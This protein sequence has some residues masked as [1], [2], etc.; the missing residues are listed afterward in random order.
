MHTPTPPFQ[1]HQTSIG[2]MGF[3]LLLFSIFSVADHDRLSSSLDCI[4]RSSSWQTQE[5]ENGV[6][7]LIQTVTLHTQPPPLP[8]PPLLPL[9]PH[10]PLDPP[11]VVIH[12]Q[13]RHLLRPSVSVRS[14]TFMMKAFIKHRLYKII[15]VVAAARVTEVVYFSETFGLA[16]CGF[17]LSLSWAWALQ[18]KRNPKPGLCWLTHNSLYTDII[19]SMITFKFIDNLC[20]RYIMP[21]FFFSQLSSICVRFATNER[22]ERGNIKYKTI[23]STVDFVVC[24]NQLTMSG[25]MIVEPDSW[26]IKQAGF[27]ISHLLK[28]YKFHL[29]SNSNNDSNYDSN[30]QNDNDSDNN[31][32]DICDEASQYLCADESDVHPDFQL[33]N[34]W[35]IRIFMPFDFLDNPKFL[36]VL[37]GLKHTS[38]PVDTSRCHLE[39]LLQ[40][41]QPP[42]PTQSPPQPPPQPTQPPTQPP[43][44]TQ[45]PKQPPQPPTQPP[46]QPPPTQPPTQPP[47]TQ[48]PTQPPPTQPPTQPPPTQPPPPP[49]PQVGQGRAKDET[50]KEKVSSA[51]EKQDEPVAKSEAVSL[52][53]VPKGSNSLDFYNL[54]TDEG[55][56]E[57]IWKYAIAKNIMKDP[58]EGG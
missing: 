43:Q 57:R 53:V 35:G 58:R 15:L 23:K 34:L 54:N 29:R 38:P 33:N 51:T 19:F 28:K 30:N 10:P 4:E 14:I 56:Q 47:P 42:Q 9:P 18:Q 21:Y 40:P 11:P 2:L 25:D 39:H 24:N 26:T 22:D 48:P 16:R 31:I 32:I 5:T 55:S 27:A 13:L 46:T 37:A 20:T 49:P 52:C 7:P 45:P 17:Y 8:L 41:P 1:S 6:K 3:L 50:D 12:T 36:A 44:P